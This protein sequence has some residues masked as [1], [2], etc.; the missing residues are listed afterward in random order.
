MLILGLAATAYSADTRKIDLST[1]VV[2]PSDGMA[3]FENPATLPKFQEFLFDVSLYSGSRDLDAVG[4][5]SGD[6]NKRFGWAVGFER[7]GD[8]YVVTPGIGFELQGAYFGLSSPI[9]AG[10]VLDR[11]RVGVQVGE[12][13]GPSFALVIR[14]VPRFRAYTVGVGW[15]EQESIRGELNL[16]LDF[17]SAFDIQSA[18]GVAGIAF[19]PNSDFTFTLR[20]RFRVVPSFRFSLSDFELGGHYWFTANTA[21]YVLFQTPYAEIV[22]GLK[23]RL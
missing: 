15:G 22:G 9:G 1:G 3:V 18:V 14:D 8:Q 20:Y 10:S 23:V 12:A 16:E 13:K 5:V 6:I 21:L 11:F 4:S 19:S 17:S 2:M 7:H